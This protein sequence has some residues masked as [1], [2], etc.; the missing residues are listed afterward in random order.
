MNILRKLAAAPI[1]WNQP[2]ILTLTRVSNFASLRDKLEKRQKDS[3]EQEFIKEMEFLQNK[4]SFTLVD[5]K[6]RAQDSLDKL[7]KGLKAKLSSGMEGT[8]AELVQ[9]KKILNAMTDEELIDHKKIK[10]Q[11]KQ[12]I[13]IVSQTKI[14]D[15]NLLITKFEH[16]QNMHEW[17]RDL[18]A[19]NIP[20]PKTQEEL[21][22]RYRKD[23][24]IKKSFLKFK[25]KRPHYSKG[26]TRQRI[27]WGPRKNI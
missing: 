11:Q 12:D 20:T 9:Q 15:I 16:M 13:A 1:I 18:K 5:Y 6:Q 2:S 8:E 24:P 4:P 19:R 22:Y 27:K 25:M 10:W 3:S 21:T 7:R 17:L 26:Q 23:R 14:Q